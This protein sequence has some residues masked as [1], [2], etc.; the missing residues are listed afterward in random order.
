MDIRIRRFDA[1]R[2][3]AFSGARY[4][5][6]VIGEAKHSASCV[7]VLNRQP[8]SGLLAALLIESGLECTVEQNEHCWFTLCDVH[9]A[10]TCPFIY[11]RNADEQQV[12]SIADS[13]IRQGCA[14]A[15]I[16][17]LFR[18]DTLFFLKAT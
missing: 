18:G 13:I 2:G 4:L 16:V 9:F 10:K 8:M 3:N 17:K 1:D 14:N 7:L 12:I 6:I 15:V 5:S 11:V